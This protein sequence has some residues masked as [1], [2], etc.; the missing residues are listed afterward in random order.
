[1][2]YK[3]GGTAPHLFPPKFDFGG[4]KK[5]T[6]RELGSVAP[7]GLRDSTGLCLLPSYRSYGAE[8]RH[9]GRKLNPKSDATLQ[10]WSGLYLLFRI[11]PVS[12]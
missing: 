9:G 11:P 10:L 2:Q 5:Y 3:H 6:N 8:R 4:N 1:M 7:T 12:L